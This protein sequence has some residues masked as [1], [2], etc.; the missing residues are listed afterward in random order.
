M[1]DHGLNETS[2]EIPTYPHRRDLLD[3]VAESLAHK[4]G[5]SFWGVEVGVLDGDWSLE[6]YNKFIDIN[7]HH[8]W[9]RLDIVDPWMHQP[10]LNADITN[11]NDDEQDS[12]YQA[13]S[14]RFR[15]MPHIHVHR[16]TGVEYALSYISPQDGDALD[17]VYLDGDHTLETV[18]QEL[19]LYGY[20]LAVGG[21]IMLDDYVTGQYYGVIP[22]VQ[23]FLQQHKHFS[24]VGISEANNS[25]VL[26][27][28]EW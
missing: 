26:L 4:N 24:L 6:L 21:H 25:N 28:R 10:H 11:V 9:H 15:E 23:S 20:N 12:R 5:S 2:R 18:L 13:V 27:R 8:D 16:M 17:F 3:V 1:I 19:T 14:K 7:Q 22:A